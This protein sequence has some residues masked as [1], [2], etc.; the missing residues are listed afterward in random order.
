MKKLK[1]N[2]QIQREIIRVAKTINNDFEG[3][4]IDLIAL[5]DSPKLLIQD[6]VK[7]LKLNYKYLELK[8]I[9]YSKRP[10]SGEVKIIKD[11]D[12]PVYHR[13][14][15]LVDGIIISGLTHHYLSNYLMQRSPK[16]VSILSVGKK[17]KLIKKK[18]PKCYTLFE[19]ND[20]M[21]EGYGFGSES[22]KIKKYLID[23]NK[24]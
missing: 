14:I 8:F 7:H 12:S 19:F 23:L 17:P 22:S 13:N 11:L 4:E 16:S 1:T 6:F 10:P 9:N 15:F 18:I 5:N 21:V 3:E 2:Q 20:E 24:E